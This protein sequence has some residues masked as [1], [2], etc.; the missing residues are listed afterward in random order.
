M[1]KL[2]NVHSALGLF[3][4]KWQKT[5]QTNKEKKP[6]TNKMLFNAKRKIPSQSSNQPVLHH[7]TQS[8]TSLPPQPQAQA[9]S[10]TE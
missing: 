9:R 3:H 1:N 6:T 10:Q 2:T 8:M 4:A 7:L 5:K